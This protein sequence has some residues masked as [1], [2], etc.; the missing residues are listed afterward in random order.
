VAGGHEPG[1]PGNGAGPLG[2]PGGNFGG[3]PGNG[4]G[5]GPGRCA[6]EAAMDAVN[7]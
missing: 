1:P 7:R 4:N 3:V 2:P 6:V 5:G